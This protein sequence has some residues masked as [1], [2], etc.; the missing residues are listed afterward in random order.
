[1]SPNGKWIAYTS[2][3]SG[4]NEI[5]VQNFPPGGGKWQ[6]SIMG[7]REAHWRPDGKELFYLQSTKL[8]VVEVKTDSDTF[9]RS[10]PRP[11]FDLPLPV[12]GGRNVFVP[13]ADGQ[14]FLVNARIEKT[15]LPIMWVLNGFTSLTPWKFACAGA[16]AIIQTRLF[17]HRLSPER[18]SASMDYKP[19]E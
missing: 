19:S 18:V 3:E 2:G 15:A 14:K 5:Y 12:G 4:R 9:E 8:M 6:V 11:L 7:G 1:V 16:E 13:S 10:T 17:C